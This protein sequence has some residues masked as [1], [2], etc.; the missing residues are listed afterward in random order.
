MYIN[1][2]KKWNVNVV[3]KP[4]SGVTLFRIPEHLTNQ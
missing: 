1:H 4:N 3:W 2:A